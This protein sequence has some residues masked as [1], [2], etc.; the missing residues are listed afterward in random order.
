M[1]TQLSE[2]IIYYTVGKPVDDPSDVNSFH[3]LDSLSRMTCKRKDLMA[4][5]SESV[6]DVSGTK[7]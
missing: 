3:D 7:N 2:A 5:C 4:A 6:A 1:E